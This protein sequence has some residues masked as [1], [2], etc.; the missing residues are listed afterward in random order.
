[1]GIPPGT[2]SLAPTLAGGVIVMT[3]MLRVP[4]S[5]GALNGVLLAGSPDSRD[6]TSA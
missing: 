3:G 4:R 1:M 2:S 5:R 6:T